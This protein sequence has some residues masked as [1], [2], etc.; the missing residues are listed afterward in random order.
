MDAQ[1]FLQ[2]HYL[3]RAKR[4]W[5]SSTLLYLV[6]FKEFYKTLEAHEP[7]AQIN[8]LIE[9]PACL[10]ELFLFR[11]SPNDILVLGHIS[12]QFH[13]A[14]WTMPLDIPLLS[15]ILSIRSGLYKEEA[16]I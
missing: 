11:I 16:H 15:F 13:G 6:V 4:N 7:S 12:A 9:R 2:G 10:L 1:R 3:K 14:K 8:K 5:E